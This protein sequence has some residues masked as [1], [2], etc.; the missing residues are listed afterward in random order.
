MQS[1]LDFEHVLGCGD[2]DLLQGLV[3]GQAA[4]AALAPF[5]EDDL[6][7]VRIRCAM[8]DLETVRQEASDKHPDGPW[9]QCEL[10]RTHDGLE[11]TGGTAG[12]FTPSRT[13]LAASKAHVARKVEA[14]GDLGKDG[15]GDHP[16]ENLG[17]QTFG[18]FGIGLV[19]PLGDQLLQDGVPEELEALV[20]MTVRV[21]GRIGRM[22]HGLLKQ[23]HVG[24]KR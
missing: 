8:D 4:M 21:L 16:V 5:R 14:R 20:M 24:I 22:G 18:I 2:H 17:E 1:D 9:P 3:L 6:G 19:E 11:G 7:V 10:E 13:L 12:P 15:I 23:P